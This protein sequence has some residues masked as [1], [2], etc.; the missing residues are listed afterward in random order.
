MV[1]DTN[2]YYPGRDGEFAD[3]EAGVATSSE[4]LQ[5]HLPRS[6]VVKAFNNIY[7]RH[8]ATLS[9]PAGAADRTTLPIA[10]DDSA[11]KTAA[12]QLISALGYD[13][14]DIGALADS[15]RTQPDTPVYGNPYAAAQPFWDHEGAPADAAEIRKAVEA[16]ER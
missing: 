15:W 10:G 3:L 2:N 9:R 6:R 11:A 13:T 4:L 1:I 8:L 16:A 12:A 7:F 14:I 5:R